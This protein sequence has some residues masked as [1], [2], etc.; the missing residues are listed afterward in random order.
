MKE[1]IK[2]S[3]NLNKIEFWAATTMFVFAVFFLVAKAG[4]SDPNGLWTT[5]KWSFNEAKAQYSFYS[6]YFFPQIS[7][8][9]IFYVSFLVFN[10]YITPR[11]IKR[12]NPV[13]TIFLI[14]LIIS[15]SLLWG[16]CSE[17]QIP[18]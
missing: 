4:N 5:Y 15:S 9:V 17:L 10:F 8:Y 14:L 12:E 7:K 6:N 3:L 13:L 2:N 18:I 1:F 11:V 16:C